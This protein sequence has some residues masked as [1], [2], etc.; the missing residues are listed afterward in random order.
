MVEGEYALSFVDF[1]LRRLQSLLHIISPFVE[2][3]DGAGPSEMGPTWRNSPKR[4][5]ESWA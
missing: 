1:T 5:Q 4:Q 3:D 2:L